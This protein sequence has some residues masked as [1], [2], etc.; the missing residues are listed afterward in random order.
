MYC[1]ECGN[2][3]KKGDIYCAECGNKLKKEH[4]N[5]VQSIQSISKRSKIIIG[6]VLVMILLLFGTFYILSSITS[7]QNIA[8]NYMKAIQNHDSNKIYRSFNLNSEFI[9]QEILNG[10]IKNSTEIES[11]RLKDIDYRDHKKIAIVTFLY[12]EKGKPFEKT[13]KFTLTKNKNKWIFFDNW[14]IDLSD[15]FIVKNFKIVVPKKAKVIYAGIPVSEKYF[16]KKE[17]TSKNDIYYIDYVFSL[18][19][20]IKVELENGYTMEDDILPSDYKKE[21]RASISL[22]KIDSKEREKIEEAIQKDLPII[23]EGAIQNQSFDD[24]KLK[25]DFKGN[26]ELFKKS[27]QEFVKKLNNA[28]NKLTKIKFSRITLSSIKL[29]ENGY[30]KCSFKANYN[31]SVK[32]EDYFGNEKD[33]NSTGYSYMSLAYSV[34]DKAYVITDLTYLEDYFSKY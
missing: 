1:S 7:P 21:Y 20:K 29:D 3:N 33:N 18:K 34:K 14:E 26:E 4:K 8:K 19:T 25:L 9:S 30:L 16:H 24:I 22:D 27:Y 28:N 17:S 32:Y 11:Y 13:L 23:Y 15:E 5:P 6:I 31:Y 12:K 10:L 2:K